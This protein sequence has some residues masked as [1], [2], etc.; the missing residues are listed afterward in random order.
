MSQAGQRAAH[1]LAVQ[2]VS[3]TKPDSTVPFL[4][5]ADAAGDR[6]T[7]GSGFGVAAARAEAGADVPP[8]WGVREAGR[9]ALRIWA[10]LLNAEP[11]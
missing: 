1:K 9:D 3:G 6:E 11:L 4:H 8:R 2:R 5:R 7:L 10:G